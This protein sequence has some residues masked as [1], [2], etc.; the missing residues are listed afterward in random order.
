MREAARGELDC[1]K[2]RIKSDKIIHRVIGE[3][4]LSVLH[5]K[6]GMHHHIDNVVTY[7]D[8]LGVGRHKIAPIYQ[9]T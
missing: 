7:T 1:N 9:K 5:W 4:I 6:N 3:T 2:T 8:L